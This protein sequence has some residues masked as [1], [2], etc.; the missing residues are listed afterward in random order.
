M[1]LLAALPADEGGRRDVTPVY[2]IFLT[3][4]LRGWVANRRSYRYVLDMVRDGVYWCGLPLGFRTNCLW[5]NGF[6][7]EEK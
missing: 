1:A 6:L 2:R 5:R 3:V 4:L 7:F